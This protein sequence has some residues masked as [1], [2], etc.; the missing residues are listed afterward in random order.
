MSFRSGL[1]DAALFV[2]QFAG[3]A[4]LT[5]SVAPSSPALC[6][7]L[8]RH[9]VSGGKESR[10]VLEVGPGTGAVTR[11]IARRLGPRD[12]L[13]LVEANEEF[14]GRL[15]RCLRDDA[16]L[17]AVAGRT[18]LHRGLLQKHRLGR[19][20][21]IVCGL[22]F[23][24]FPPELVT[25]LLQRM[26]GALAPGGRMAFFGYRGAR[27]AQ[28]LHP[29]RRASGRA[30][31]DAVKPH[32]LGRELVLTNLPPAWVYQLAATKTPAR[33]AATAAETARSAAASSSGPA[34]VS[35]R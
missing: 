31:H 9:V 25:D 6:R 26:L 35:I 34:P 24:N 13:E 16:A 5:G 29:P 21:A 20:D 28:L 17:A 33:A 7:A 27:V 2:R 32:L 4:A 14:A 11:H 1:A 10:A 30:L 18:R 15:E 19:Y 8:T 22:P 23:A 12:T 3:S